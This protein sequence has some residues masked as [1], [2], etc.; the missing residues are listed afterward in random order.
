MPALSPLYAITRTEPKPGIWCWTVLFRRRGKA[1]IKAF[2]ELKLG[3]SEKALAAAIKWRDAQLAKTQT[4]S[5]REFHQLVRSNNHSGVPGVQFIKPT[6]QPQ[7]SWQARLKQPDGKELT[8]T[9]AVLKYG[10]EGAFKLAVAARSE[11]LGLVEDKP[12][13]HHPTAKQFEQKRVA[14]KAPKS[15]AKP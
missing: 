14:R 6:N 13:L 7:G 11:L 5:Q 4:L 2:Y 15:Q 10:Y 8:R 12:F 3:G 9:F 1:H